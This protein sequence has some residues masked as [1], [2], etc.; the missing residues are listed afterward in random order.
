MEEGIIEVIIGVTSEGI[1]EVREEGA[2][3]EEED[4][5]IMTPTNSSIMTMLDHGINRVKTRKNH[6]TASTEEGAEAITEENIEEEAVGVDEEGISMGLGENLG[7][8]TLT[9]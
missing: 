1:E 8:N 7:T 5:E 4:V 3:I 6:G 2:A 9:R